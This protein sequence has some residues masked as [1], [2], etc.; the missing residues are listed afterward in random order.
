MS[1]P[2]TGGDVEIKGARVL[3]AGATGVLGGEL[4]RALAAAG[5]RLAL[6]GRDDGRLQAG[7]MV[8]SGH[9][10]ARVTATGARTVA[11][12]RSRW[13]G[14]RRRRRGGQVGEARPGSR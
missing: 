14:Q 5:A 12:R 2:G 3:V 10:V 6:T 4:A 8:V 13:V 9:G 11:G 7:A 1:G